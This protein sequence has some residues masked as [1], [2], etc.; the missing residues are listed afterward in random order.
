[1]SCK[2]NYVSSVGGNICHVSKTIGAATIYTMHLSIT[3]CLDQTHQSSAAA[4]VSHNR[5]YVSVPIAISLN[6]QLRTVSVVHFLVECSE[7]L[8]FIDLIHVRHLIPPLHKLTRYSTESPPFRG[9]GPSYH[10]SPHG[11]SHHTV[12]LRDEQLLSGHSEQ[13]IG[14]AVRG[15]W[16]VYAVP[17][18]CP[19]SV[20]PLPAQIQWLHHDHPHHW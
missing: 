19:Q 14:G 17:S 10:H 6:S 4:S 18:F 2:V 11:V 13:F 1:M 8:E 7:Q 20:A 3:F 16:S 12:P 15:C 9:A 5:P